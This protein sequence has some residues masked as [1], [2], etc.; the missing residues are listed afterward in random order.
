MDRKETLAI[1]SVMKAAYP[2]FYKNLTKQ[3]AE[4]I[5]NLWTT[6]LSEVPYEV[7]GAAVKAFIAT[8]VKGYP[9]HIGA[10]IE[11]ITALRERDAM[12][13]QEAWAIVRKALR[14]SAYDSKKEF[15]KLPDV[16]KDVISTPDTLKVWATDENFNESVI[17]SNFMRSYR[18][19]AN[20]KRDFQKLPGD[21]QKL[22]IELGNSVAM[23]EE[24][25]EKDSI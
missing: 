22:A 2:A 12:T 20:R 17:S 3:E 6:M 14:N 24:K 21:V 5:V 9:P 25:S 1:L 23:I 15:E 10:V 11:Q 16:I 19:R 18:V 8:D 4:G 13:E 7:V